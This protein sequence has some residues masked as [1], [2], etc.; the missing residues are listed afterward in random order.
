MA[1]RRLVLVFTQ[2]TAAHRVRKVDIEWNEGF[3]KADRGVLC[4]AA[5]HAVRQ[6]EEPWEFLCA[7]DSQSTD[8]LLTAAEVGVYALA[9]AETA[10]TL[11][12][13]YIATTGAKDEPHER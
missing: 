1:E 9:E 4:D 5:H 12:Y 10:K 7:Y 6:I 13:D 11:P 2:G 3:E 8:V